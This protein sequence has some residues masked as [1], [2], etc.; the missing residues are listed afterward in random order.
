MTDIAQAARGP[1]VMLA[2][3]DA[4]TTAPH[5]RRIPAAPAP[6]RNLEIVDVVGLVRETAE[7][8]ESLPSDM[9]AH[10]ALAQ[11][12][13][14]FD[15]LSL[16]AAV[17]AGQNN[18]RA[19]QFAAISLA[20]VDAHARIAEVVDENVLDDAIDPRVTELLDDAESLLR[21]RVSA[22]RVRETA[23]RTADAT[24]SV[25]ARLAATELPP[26][27]HATVHGVGAIVDDIRALLDGP[28]HQRATLAQDYYQRIVLEAE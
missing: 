1:V 26:N 19:D 2:R 27:L 3:Q 14:G 21:V 5:D 4:C 20:G 24:R 6:R 8:L 23:M 22:R 17:L 25:L 13:T 15:A 10:T 7:R 28:A 11:A 16:A 9:P 18:S 12:H